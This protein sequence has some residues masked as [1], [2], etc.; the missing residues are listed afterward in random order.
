M[1]N[2]QEIFPVH[3]KPIHRIL[4]TLLALVAFSLPFKDQFLV[5]LFIILAAAVWLLSN[6]FNQLFVKKGNVKSLFAI[7]IFY[8]LHV[9]ALLYTKNIEEGFFNLEIKA[10]LFIL[11]LIFYSVDYTSKQ[12]KFLLKNFI[13]GC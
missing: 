6:P 2:L 11:P 4:L 5:N 9:S 3:S 12:N 13:S 1:L 7:A 10:T 8:S